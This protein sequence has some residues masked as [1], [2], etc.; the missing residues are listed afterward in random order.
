ML[1]IKATI[2]HSFKAL[3]LKYPV[4]FFK[5]LYSL[6][7]L[8]VVHSRALALCPMIG[9]YINLSSGKSSL[10][11]KKSFW[12]TRKSY[13]CG[14]TDHIVQLETQGSE[15]LVNKNWSLAKLHCYFVESSQMFSLGLAQS[16]LFLQLRCHKISVHGTYMIPWLFVFLVDRYS[17]LQS[18]YS[19]QGDRYL[20]AGEHLETRDWKL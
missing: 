1:G 7:V 8:V 17:S 12:L 5:L 13:K 6:M 3:L 9:V 15:D 16:F 2:V 18:S 11:Y 14:W 10:A 19:F 20:L 4:F